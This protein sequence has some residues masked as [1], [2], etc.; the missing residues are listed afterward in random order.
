M[1]LFLMGDSFTENLF[2]IGYNDIGRVKTNPQYSMSD[3]EICRYL[4]HLEQNGYEKAKYFEDLL[5]DMG[6]EVYNFAKSGC[7]IEDI[8]YQFS[9]LSKFENKDDDR[10]I[11]NWTHPSRFNWVKDDREINYVHSNSNMLNEDA[12]RNDSGIVS[13]IMQQNINREESFF[14]GYLNRNLL[15]FMEYLIEIHNK[16]KPIVWTPFADLDKTMVNQKWFFS[17]INEK[18][19]W[20][21]L[22]KLPHN[23]SIIDETNGLFKDYHFGRYGNYYIAT[24][25]DEIIK[26]N[27]G[28]TYADDTK[29]FDIVLRRIE[30]ENKIFKI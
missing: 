28:P 8:I 9:N 14:D 2:E 18:Y 24:L 23:L 21:F 13:L 7:T 29:I 19:W 5:V 25:F 17:F 12:W 16:Y 11:L 3:P 30:R 27:L 22:G 4:I 1:R 20:N 15:P 26:N 6:Y 10:I